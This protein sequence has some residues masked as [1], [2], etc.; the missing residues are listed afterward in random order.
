MK[1]HLAND[2]TLLQTSSILVQNL[3]SDMSENSKDLNAVSGTNA[4]PCFKRRN[5]LKLKIKSPL[6]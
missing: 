4:D 1:G 3:S 2:F 5:R 6:N